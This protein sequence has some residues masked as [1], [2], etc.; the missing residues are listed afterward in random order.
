MRYTDADLLT[1]DEAKALLAD[2]ERWIRRTGTNYFRLTTAARVPPNT[3]SMIRQGKRRPTVKIA[4]RIRAAMSAN[5]RGIDRDK[6]LANRLA[7]SSEPRRVPARRSATA[8]NPG[9]TASPASDR[10]QNTSTGGSSCSANNPDTDE[11]I[12]PMASELTIIEPQQS[13][14]VCL[15][16]WVAEGRKLASIRIEIDWKLGDWLAAGRDQFDP[17][18]I[19][20]ALGEIAADVE[21]ARALKRVEK[22]ARAFPVGTRDTA[23]TFEHH[24]KVADL[25]RQEALPLLREAREEKLPASKLRIRAMLKKVDLGMVLPREDDPEY[26]AM[27]ACVRAWN[28]APLDVREDFA[29][30]VGESHLGDIEP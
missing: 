21:Q 29:E 13:P 2:M 9:N 11:R 27:L 5:P 18:Q 7:P 10:G 15:D 28:R 22:V 12:A 23:L 6:H 30:M 17:E 1:A 8:G 14:A 4:M 19:E 16:D 20:M 3:R 26:D 25:P 24:A